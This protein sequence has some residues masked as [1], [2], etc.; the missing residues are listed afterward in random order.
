[1]TGTLINIIAILIG[2]TLGSLMGDRFPERFRLIFMQALGL[3]ITALAIDMALETK[4]FLVVLL[5]ILLGV[6]LGE[7]WDIDKRLNHLGVWLEKKA[8]RFPI[9]TKGNFTR[10]FVASSL[11]VCIGPLA[12]LGSIQDGL[13]GDYTLLAIKSA[14]DFVVTIALGAAFGFGVVF[15]ALSILVVQGG[16]TLGASLVQGLMTEAMIAE[17]SATGGVMLMGLG[18]TMLE[19]KRIKVANFLPALFIVPF[20]VL[21]WQRLGL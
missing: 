13:S 18:L 12:I 4:E 20:L 11:I 16:M 8:Q 21:L 5:A 3:L 1:M 2:G 7:W 17:F 19:I 14:M 10:G 6:L 9:L 15:S